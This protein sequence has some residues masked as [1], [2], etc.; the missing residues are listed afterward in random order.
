MANH[1]KTNKRPINEEKSF[2]QIYNNM[3]T[4]K[5]DLYYKSIINAHKDVLIRKTT[6]RID[7][8]IYCYKQRYISKNDMFTEIESLRCKNYIIDQVVYEKIQY[9]KKTFCR[10]RKGNNKKKTSYTGKNIKK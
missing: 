10:P 7:Y 1:T 2:E 8:I 9:V 5:R 3:K 6:E 4:L